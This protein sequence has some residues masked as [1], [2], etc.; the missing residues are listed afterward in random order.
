MGITDSTQTKLKKLQQKVVKASN[1]IQNLTK[2]QNNNIMA[3]QNQLNQIIIK[4][5][6]L[7]GR[8]AKD[9]VNL[10]YLQIQLNN[11]KQAFHK[12]LQVINSRVQTN[13]DIVKEL[14][15]NISSIIAQM[16]KMRT[17][18]TENTGQTNQCYL[19]LDKLQKKIQML[20][21]WNDSCS[22]LSKQPLIIQKKVKSLL[23]KIALG[24]II[25]LILYVLGY[26][27]SIVY[28]EFIQKQYKKTHTQQ[29]Q[30]TNKE[31]SNE[32]GK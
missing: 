18:L 19:G 15:T 6:Q 23:L 30:Q 31:T 16:Y 28:N 11:H 10:K 25:P 21:H 1:T 22:S 2:T 9:Q 13:D 32:G 20:N 5:T 8:F 27:G 3:I 24:I 29:I 12:L 7:Q 4:I 26:F 14:K 17:Q